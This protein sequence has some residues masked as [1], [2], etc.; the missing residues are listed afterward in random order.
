MTGRRTLA[1]MVLGVVLA[2]AGVMAGYVELELA[3]PE[4][5]ADR[6]VAALRS[7]EVRG[8]IAEQVAVEM[9]ERGSP[10]I[11]ASRPI[12]LTAVEA[13]LETDQFEPV[14]RRTAVTAH[15]LLFRGDRDVIVELQE[16][17][18]VLLP[19]VE[20]VS[21]EVARQIPVKLTP[22]IAEIRRGHVATW[23]VRVADGVGVAAVPLLIAAATALGLGIAL[24]PDRR[25]ALGTAGLLLSAGAV[26]GLLAMAAL[27]AQVI[28]HAG[29]VGVLSEDDARAA[30]GAAWGALAGGLER[31]FAIVGTA[32]LAVAAGML[33]AEARVDR[34]A[35]LRHAADILAGGAL[36]RAVKLLRG[37]ALAV[38]GALILLG[39]QPVL[40]VAVVVFG[41]ALVVLGLAEAV[42]T[43]SGSVPRERSDE[44]K[45]RRRSV[46]AGA[47]ALLVA[48]VAGVALLSG[49]GSPAAL[50]EA[51]ITAC[52]GLRVLCDR[53]LDEIVLP[54]THNSMSSADRPG[55]FFA[56]QIRP[57]PR[58]LADGIRF[59]MLDPHYGVVDS[60]GRV[61][62]DLRAEG[63]SRNR[64]ARRLGVDAVEAAEG[65][66][67][68]LGIVPTEGDRGVFL[69]HTLCE[70]G[71][72][73]MSVTL[74]EIRAFLERNRSEVLVV[75]LESSVDS[76]D[77]EQEIDDADL[78]PYLATLRRGPALPTL[79]ELIAAGR[80]L[81]VFD[82]DDGGEASWYQPGFVFMQ[83]TKIDSLLNSPVACDPGRGAPKSP[84]LLMNHWIDRFP[85]SPR[86]NRAVSDRLTL[87]RRVRSCRE[88]LGRAPNLI[89]VD[90][91]ERSEVVHIARKLNR[92]GAPVSHGG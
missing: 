91:Y 76:R 54:G 13:V 33:I 24:A 12:V 36:P 74:D 35:A 7:E 18:E 69:C 25:R 9:L 82:E 37:L 66:A 79:R 45:R 48:A 53:R 41:A 61:R 71:A 75:F 73:R 70:L 21:P 57:I 10:D 92:D 90:F 1:L 84:L 56:N 65:L 22:R 85:P 27:R 30:A 58:Q 83:D 8:V 2:L 88:A 28:S 60:Q 52:N 51:E 77:V 89:A 47:A 46:I 43:V 39:A 72:E 63:T 6:A 67:G 86:R 5:F 68:R 38:L 78:E 19:A 64:V 32:G 4:P 23:A 26:G 62:T 14:L 87:L 59:L 16:A 80:R 31:W 34:A 44:P 81:V 50:D 40:A 20:S 15:Q 3:R 11:V 55:W 42:S 17:R 49:R 29:E